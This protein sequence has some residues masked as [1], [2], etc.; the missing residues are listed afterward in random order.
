MLNMLLILVFSALACALLGTFL[1]LRGMAMVVDAMSH[2]VLLGVVLFYFIF[3]DLGSPFLFV[4]ASLMAVLTVMAIEWLIK[5]QMVEEDAAI[6]IVFPFFFS[7]AVILI[8]KF[9]RNTHLDLDSVF[10]GNIL[11]SSLHTTEI[12][13]ITLPR[14]IVDMGVLLLVIV[15]LLKLFY[16]ELKL[17]S[18]DYVYASVIG[19]PVLLLHYGL[20]SLV[21]FTSVYAFEVLGIILVISLMVA[22]AAS[23]FLWSKDLKKMLALASIFALVQV[24][25][26]LGI[27]HQL[28]LSITGLSAFIGGL[29]FVL[30]FLTKRFLQYF[31]K[32]HLIKAE[33]PVK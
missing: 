2:S 27:A 9:F 29:L 22:P 20:M 4:G 16:K 5:T 15:V 17:L 12:M 10:M 23:A 18:F 14:A 11:F 32:S 13:G 25:L 28:D 6:G 8:S 26:G 19:L 30:S 31:H 7:L 21:A 1:V 33:K 3:H 24:F